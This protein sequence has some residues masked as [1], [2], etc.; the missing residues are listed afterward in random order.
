MEMDSTL[1]GMEAGKVESWMFRE[2]VWV[3]HYSHRIIVQIEVCS[4]N[5][6]SVNSVWSLNIL[7]LCDPTG[8]Q[9][10]SLNLT[11]SVLTW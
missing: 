7:P 11:V 9:N 6:H 10:G 2:K 4:T 5:L 3:L 1:P 8:L